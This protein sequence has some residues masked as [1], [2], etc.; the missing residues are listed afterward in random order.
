MKLRVSPWVK[1]ELAEREDR[2]DIDFM[3]KKLKLLDT[4]DTDHTVYRNG[5]N[6]SANSTRAGMHYL[7]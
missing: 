5:L 7:T 3:Q 6:R 2:L 1:F 4:K